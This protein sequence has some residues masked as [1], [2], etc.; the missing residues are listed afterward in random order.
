MNRLRKYLEIFY[1]KSLGPNPEEFEMKCHRQMWDIINMHEYNMFKVAFRFYISLIFQ[2]F[3]QTIYA[4]IHS[5][6]MLL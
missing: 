2:V 6:L 1:D 5:F 4:F 3:C